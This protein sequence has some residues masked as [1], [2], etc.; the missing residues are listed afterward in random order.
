MK[1]DVVLGVAAGNQWPELMQILKKGGKYG[2]IGGPLVE[3]D[4]RDLYYKKDDHVEIYK[5]NG[6]FIGAQTDTGV[7]VADM[8]PGSY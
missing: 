6:K 4:I 7:A 3:L 1:V 5:G 8:S 2:T